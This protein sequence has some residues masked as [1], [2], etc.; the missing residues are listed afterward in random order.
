ML[1]R[2]GGDKA[3]SFRGIFCQTVGKE[4]KRYVDCGLEKRQVEI[5]DLKFS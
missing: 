4:V 2:F 3:I 5:T 1:K